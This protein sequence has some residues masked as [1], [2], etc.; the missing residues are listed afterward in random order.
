MSGRL[1]RC[2]SGQ[3]KLVNVLLDYYNYFAFDGLGDAM[4][5]IPILEVSGLGNLSFDRVSMA[6]NY[7]ESPQSQRS[8]FVLGCFK[9]F[10]SR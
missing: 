6:S 2:K 8:Y 3:V 4:L 7:V 10:V 5:K 9:P 1:R